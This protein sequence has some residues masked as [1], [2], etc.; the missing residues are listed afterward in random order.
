MESAGLGEGTVE[1]IAENAIYG[2]TEKRFV[3]RGA[4]MNGVLFG[5][6]VQTR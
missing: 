5:A 1:A 6:T 4:E 2:E 3:G